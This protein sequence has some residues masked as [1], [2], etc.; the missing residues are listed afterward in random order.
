MRKD[1]IEE[2]SMADVL[3]SGDNRDEPSIHPLE[4]PPDARPLP[5]A[6]GLEI[7][8]A[9]SLQPLRILRLSIGGGVRRKGFF[10]LSVRL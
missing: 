9:A 2:H 3:A 7:A 5:V 6:D 8:L 4:L 10:F 1:C